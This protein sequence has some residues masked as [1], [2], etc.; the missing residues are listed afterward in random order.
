M[1]IKILNTLLFLSHILLFSSILPAFALEGNASDGKV[2]STTCMACHGPTGNS[3][4]P[5]WPSIAG[6]HANYLEEALLSYKDGS[7][8]DPVMSP[9]TLNLSDQDIADLATYYEGQTIT[10]H[11][12][13]KELVSSGER[14]YRGGNK[15]NNTSA[16]IACH[17]PK[18]R[19]NKPARYP[20]LT[21]QFAVY[22]AQQLEKYKNG[23]R[24]TDGDKKIMRMI[25]S[26]LT[27]Q[28]IKAVASYIQGLR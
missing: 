26:T 28:E 11:S 4:V 19:G 7:R 27:D 22:T 9:Q 12:A 16:C 17:G 2:K 20:S 21:G 23:V 18:G 25:A 14:I 15:E 8:E 5:M 10:L 24:K 1:N 13:D 6:Q 3:V